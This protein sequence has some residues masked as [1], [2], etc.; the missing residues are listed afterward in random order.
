MYSHTNLSHFLFSKKYILTRRLIYEIQQQNTG[1]GNIRVYT[2]SALIK[3]HLLFQETTLDVS[4]FKLMEPAV[5]LHDCFCPHFFKHSAYL[6][7]RRVRAGHFNLNTEFRDVRNEKFIYF[8]NTSEGL[9]SS[10]TSVGFHKKPFTCENCSSTFS[11]ERYLKRHQKKV[12][13]R[14]ADGSP[15]SEIFHSV[16]SRRYKISSLL[17]YRKKFSNYNVYSTRYVD[18][19]HLM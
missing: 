1:T 13:M 10:C 4:T 15:K 8:R 14:E 3:Y 19:G 9:S 5:L 12:H 18:N 17:R 6:A 7:T 2:Y 11:Q 16:F